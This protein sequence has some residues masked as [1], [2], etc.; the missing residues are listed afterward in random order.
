MPSSRGNKYFNRARELPAVKELF[1]EIGSFK[2]VAEGKTKERRLRAELRRTVDVDY[3]GFNK[4]MMIG[5]K[6]SRVLGRWRE[7]G[8]KG[9]LRIVHQFQVGE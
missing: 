7:R 1:G 3:Y 5:R 8:W 9:H 6:G 2:E 4:K